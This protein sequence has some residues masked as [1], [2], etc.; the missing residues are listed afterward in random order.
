M[1]TWPL[2]T[3]VRALPQQLPEGVGAC[4]SLGNLWPCPLVSAG[5][6]DQ[7]RPCSLGAG[8]GGRGWAQHG[9]LCCVC[10]PVILHD[11]RDPIAP[12][13]PSCLRT[14][15][16][17]TAVVEGD[18]VCVL[19][20]SSPR[21]ERL[22]LT[23]PWGEGIHEFQVRASP[24]RGETFQVPFPSWAWQQWQDPPWGHS[25]ILDPEGLWWEL[26]PHPH[27]CRLRKPGCYESCWASWLLCY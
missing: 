24:G 9:P 14:L 16:V 23:L 26:P 12:C 4:R 25:F 6:T 8:G 22:D 15:S 13:F 27:L 3:R 11:C 7:G 2:P 5:R 19:Q 20:V 1:L 17:F 18:S 21:R 10:A